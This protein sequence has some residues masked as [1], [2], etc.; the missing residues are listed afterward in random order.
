MRLIPTDEKFHELFIAH[1]ERVQEAA[2]KLEAMTASYT[3]VQEQ[4]AAIRAVEKEGEERRKHFK[5]IGGI[6]HELKGQGGTFGYPLISVFGKSLNELCEKEGGSPTDNQL[7]IVKAHIDVMKAVIKDRVS[8]DGGDL[9]DAL[10][11][12]VRLAPDDVGA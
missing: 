12:R 5:H 6:A 7:E 2:N 8:G 3:N 11:H 10:G 4:V 1:G 9:G